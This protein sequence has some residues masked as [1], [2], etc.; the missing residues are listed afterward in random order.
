MCCLLHDER[1]QGHEARALDRVGELALVPGTNAG[2]LARH[3]LSKRGEIALQGVGVLVV[4][5][6]HVGAAEGALARDGFLW[7]HNDV[8][9]VR[10]RAEGIGTT[11]V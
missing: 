10:E 11:G 7:R 6:V 4:D 3:D 9:L 1:Q 8:F 2:A 5:F